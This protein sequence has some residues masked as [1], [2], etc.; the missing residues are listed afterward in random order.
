MTERLEEETQT[1]KNG[2]DDDDDDDDDA[3]GFVDED[4]NDQAKNL[5]WFVVS[6][7]VVSFHRARDERD[8]C[9]WQSETRLGWRGKLS[10]QSRGRRHL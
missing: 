10:Q 5:H 7:F 8:G 6:I 9:R 4:V 2:A 3:R 1:V